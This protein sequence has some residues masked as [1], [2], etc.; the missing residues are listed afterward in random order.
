MIAE[1]LANRSRESGVDFRS[2]SQKIANERI[3]QICQTIPLIESSRVYHQIS[4]K[5]MS[6][7]DFL[8]TSVFLRGFDFL[9]KG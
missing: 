9:P 5:G 2:S 4:G 8:S 1:Y 3:Y 6:D 7:D